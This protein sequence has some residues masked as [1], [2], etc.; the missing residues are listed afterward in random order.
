V[1]REW[2]VLLDRYGGGDRVAVAEAWV[3][4]PERLARY[5]RHDE[6]HQAFNFHFLTADFDALAWGRAIEDSLRV[7]GLV[8]APPTWVLSNH[9]VRRHRTRYGPGA[10]GLRRARAAALLTLALPGSAYLYQGEELGLPEVEDLP[11]DVLAD[12]VWERSGHT[13]RGR[14]GCRVPLPWIGSAPPFGFGPPGGAPPWLPVPAG[15]AELTVEA[16]WADPAST[17]S[18]YRKALEIRRAHPA[19]G[20]GTLS[21]GEGPRDTLF[22]RREPGFACTANFGAT[23]VELP[24]PGRPLL[25]SGPLPGDGGKAILPP[26]T[27]AWWSTG[28]R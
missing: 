23:P 8:G 24:A 12:P 21:W 3:P 22:F 4:G 14:D 25:A 27:V 28:E 19:L 7:A 1:Y 15:W 16:Q 11:T 13:E 2:R 26:D 5:V 20:D 17:L 10:D 9:D 6:L 18:L